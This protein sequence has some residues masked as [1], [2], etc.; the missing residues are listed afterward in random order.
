M[1]DNRNLIK[2][3]E[4]C[5]SCHLGTADK[6]VDH[7]MIAAGHPDLTFEI[8]YFTFYMP[9]HWKTP[10]QDNAWRSVQAWGVGQAV[11]LRESL[12]RLARRTE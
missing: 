6:F 2:R 7:E 1:Y 3:S 10:E 9:Q 8:S 5:L 4:K 11:Q 12:Y